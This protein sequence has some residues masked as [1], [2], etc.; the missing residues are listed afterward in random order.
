MM[1]L[2]IA[3]PQQANTICLLH[4]LI[5]INDSTITSFCVFSIYM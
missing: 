1:A 3:A 4:L 5:K 2:F